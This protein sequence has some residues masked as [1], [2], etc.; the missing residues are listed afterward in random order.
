M[1]TTDAL[2]IVLAYRTPSSLEARALANYLDDA[3]IAS[4][5]VGEFLEGVY[6]GLS[7]GRMDEKEVWVAAKDEAAA[8]SLVAQWRS[9]NGSQEPQASGHEN[10]AL[11]WAWILALLALLLIGLP[12][13]L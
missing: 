1:S 4:H 3:G 7:F 10:R 13:R 12:S 9:E 8:A 2:E 11:H 6:A 5:V